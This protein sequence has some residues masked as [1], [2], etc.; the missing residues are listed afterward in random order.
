MRISPKLEKGLQILGFNQEREDC[1]F[2]CEDINLIDDLELRIHLEKA[3]LFNANAVFFRKEL[4][5]FKPQVYLYDFT[6]ELFNQDNLTD[7]QKKVWSNGTV[8]IVCAFYDAEIKILDCTQ[9]IK[10]DNTPVYLANLELVAR[11]HQ[12][13]N[14]QFAVKI[15]TGTFWEEIENKNKFKFNSSAYDILIKWIKEIIRLSSNSKDISQNKIVKKVIIQSIM[16]KYLEERKDQ[17]GKSPFNKKYVRK[18]DNAKDFVEV[19]EKNK[20]V[21]LLEDLQRDLNGN[22]FEW[23][24]EEK[25]AIK[26][27]D[28][29]SLSEALKAY[30]KPEEINNNIFELI[31]F[32]EFSYIPVELISRI[33]EE[34]LAG[35]ADVDL[36][37]MN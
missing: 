1:L 2:L 17:N 26:L 23:S 37:Q 6:N 29:S 34:F 19:L 10:K 24:E 30:K 21:D 32:Y 36:N 22:L 7:I 4:D 8:P 11:A 5:R 25:E 20:L 27:I 15:K 12:L 13:Y 18:Y 31:R 9:H 28:L 14:K 33:Y 3:I 35:V 16:I